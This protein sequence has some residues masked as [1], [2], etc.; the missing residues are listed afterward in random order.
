MFA[1]K[2]THK[3]SF[4]L[5][6][7]FLVKYRVYIQHFMFFHK[8]LFVVF[9]NFSYKNSW[10]FYENQVVILLLYILTI[11]VN[12][13]A[14]RIRKLMKRWNW[15]LGRTC[16]LQVSKPIALPL[17]YQSHFTVSRMYTMHLV[18]HFNAAAAR[19]TRVP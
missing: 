3:V 8:M 6:S 12:S 5:Q 10:P 11:I 17:S 13:Y 2:I 7:F 1:I 15:E 19:W 9:L 4:T 14:Q 18:G 16:D